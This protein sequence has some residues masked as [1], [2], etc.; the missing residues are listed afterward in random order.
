MKEVSEELT[1]VISEALDK[2]Y[3]STMMLSCNMFK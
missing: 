1:A 3:E 2:A